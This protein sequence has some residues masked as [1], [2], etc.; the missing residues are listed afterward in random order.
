MFIRLGSTRSHVTFSFS[1]FGSRSS[2][3]QS[4]LEA[5][6]LRDDEVGQGEHWK[7]GQTGTLMVTKLGD[8]FQNMFWENPLEDEQ[9]DFSSAV[10]VAWKTRLFIEYLIP[11]PNYKRML[12]SS[13]SIEDFLLTGFHNLFPEMPIGAII[14]NNDDTNVLHPPSLRAIQTHYFPPRWSFSTY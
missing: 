5:S 4:S 11:I 12:Y 13:P 6:S 3:V 9:G 8:R 14:S 1:L 10:F 7:Q 2:W